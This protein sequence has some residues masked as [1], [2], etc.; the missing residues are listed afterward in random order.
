MA[1]EKRREK[2]EA[3]I[4]SDADEARAMGYEST[5]RVHE[6]RRADYRAAKERERK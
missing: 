1:D 2:I 4:Q 6:Q 5:A 3:M